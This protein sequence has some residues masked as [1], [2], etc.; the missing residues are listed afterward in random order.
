MLL[1]AETN[2]AWMNFRNK[3]AIC[4]KSYMC[5]HNT[6]QRDKVQQHCCTPHHVTPHRDACNTRHVKRC[7]AIRHVAFRSS[8]RKSISCFCGPSCTIPYRMGEDIEKQP[9]LEKVDEKA[10]LSHPAGVGGFR[11]FDDATFW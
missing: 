10:G 11:H 2:V 7:T 6:M 4:K 8:F 5:I 9:L 3:G 1:G